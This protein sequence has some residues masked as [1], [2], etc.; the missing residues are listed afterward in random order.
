[1]TVHRLPTWF[2]N[3]FMLL[4]AVSAVLGVLPAY[5]RSLTTT[6]LIAILASV[7]LYFAIAYLTRSW[8]AVRMVSGVVILA[9]TLLAL[10]F[11]TQFGYQGYPET[12]TLIEQFGRITTLPIR[13]GEYLHPNAVAAFLGVAVPLGITRALS[14]RYVWRKGFWALCSLIIVYALFLTYSR[15][16]WLALGAA[17]A[18]VIVL[19]ILKRLPRRVAFVV[20]GIGLIAL[21]AGLVTIIIL[22]TDNLPFLASVFS[23]A[24]SRG[25]LY[26]NSLYLL[27][28]Y[29]YSGIGLGDT[30]AMVYSRYALLIFVPFLTYAHNLPLA[31]WL[32]HGLLGLLS[33]GGII[34]ALYALVYRVMRTAEPRRLFHGAWLGV[35]VGLLHGLTDAPQ[36]A[37]HRWVMPMLFIALGL[38]VAGGRIAVVEM[39]EYEAPQPVYWR[40]RIALTAAVVVM[41]A[42]VLAIFNRPLMAAW[43]TNLGA[44]D[45]A[46]AELAPGPGS[47][48]DSIGQET[49]ST[50]VLTETERRAYF[51]S[52]EAWYRKALDAD[53]SYP[54][55]NRRLGNLLVNLGR[56]DEAVPFLETA[57][58]TEPTYGATIKGLGLAYVWVGRI[59]D[60]VRTIGLHDDPGSI[61]E[62]LGT[63][64]YFHNEQDRP[65]LAARAWEAAQFMYP[66]SVNIDVW[67]LIADTY[68]SANDADSARRWYERVLEVE[69]DNQW[70]QDGLEQP[71]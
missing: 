60:A 50:V 34:I 12:P 71:G 55:A 62:E 43:Y 21:A 22:G 46:R 10:Y 8:L 48:P 39:D 23:T 27:G 9:S 3:F 4:F 26:R 19:G 35:T 41:L 24:S 58:A 31:V 63:W 53:A 36:Y 42:G 40:R 28:D 51:A 47:I 33:F 2:L 69:P 18:L 54:N 49:S 30:F 66:D 65:L 38:T 56:Y 16:S 5:D 32:N 29:P 1:M 59:D 17:T 52:A 15:G 45:E 67:L 6:A 70:A 64:G 25:Q 11:I 68:R 13:F 14:S 20:V 44:I 7:A 37:D 61:A 57:F